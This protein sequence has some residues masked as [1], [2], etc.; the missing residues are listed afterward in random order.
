MKQ[1]LTEIA[2]LDTM[3][4]KL[5]RFKQERDELL[6]KLRKKCKHIR[7]AEFNRSP[8]RRI[9]VD[10]GAEE[11]GWYC[12]YHVLVMTGD[13]WKAPHKQDQ[14]LV[15]KTSDSGRFCSYRK[16]GVL[17]PVGQSHPNFAGGGKKPMNN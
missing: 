8:P 2:E 13:T 4:E 9:C 1:T 16:D 5:K 12:G 17:Y 14:V 11:K 6:R 7:L 15:E 3:N 10:C